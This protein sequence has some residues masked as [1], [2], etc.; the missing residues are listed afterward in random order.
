MMYI[1]CLHNKNSAQKY[2]TKT[3]ETMKGFKVSNKL[4][5]N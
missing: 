5:L 3:K 1:R 4:V 2:D